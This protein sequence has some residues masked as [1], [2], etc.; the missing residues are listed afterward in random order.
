M[1]APFRSNAKA[2]DAA[3]FDALLDEVSPDRCVIR[4]H[5]KCAV[6]HVPRG[7]PG[8]L[9]EV[10]AIPP[11]GRVLARLFDCDADGI[12]RA[13]KWAAQRNAEGFNVYVGINPRRPGTRRDRPASA[14][15]VEVATAHVLDLDSVGDADSL[16]ASLSPSPRFVVTTGTIPHTRAHCW[17]LFGEPMR[18]LSRWSAAQRRLA[19]AT[20]GDSAVS[21]PAR[22]VRLGG[23]VSYPTAS[24][25]K[26]GYIVEVTSVARIASAAQTIAPGALTMLCGDDTAREPASPADADDP[27]ADVPRTNLTP[28]SEARVRD[29]LSWIPPDLKRPAWIKVCGALR[30]WERATGDDGFT[31]FLQWSRGDLR[32]DGPAVPASFEGEDDCQRTWDSLK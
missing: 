24:K 15:D 2:I 12:A 20:G 17:W 9:V 30:E 26:R 4:R 7:Y 10:R 25:Q 22:V 16:I 6:G 11:A 19:A 29:A 18:D 21:D 5:L 8:G 1:R 28:P 23:S 31:L 13:V 3:E 27:F 32:R 14:A